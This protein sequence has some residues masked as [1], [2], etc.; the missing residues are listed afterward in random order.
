VVVVVKGSDGKLYYQRE[1]SAAAI[2]DFGS[3]VA[4]GS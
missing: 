4:A 2:G 1:S 3:W